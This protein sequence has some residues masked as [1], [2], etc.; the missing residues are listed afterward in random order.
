MARGG[1]LTRLLA[2][3]VARLGGATAAAAAT[4]GVVTAVIL[5]TFHGW[6]AGRSADL[7]GWKLAATTAVAAAL[8][9]VMVALKNLV[10]VHLH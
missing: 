5:L 2:L 4:V 1:Q 7:H 9:L 8:G 3:L 6:T 10:I